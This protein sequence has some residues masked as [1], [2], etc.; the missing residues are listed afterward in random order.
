MLTIVIP[1]QE[2]YRRKT[3]TFEYLTKEYTIRLEHSLISVSKWETIYKKPY[4]TTKMNSREFV[5]YVKCMTINQDV[6]DL[7]YEAL[8]V[9]DIKKISEYIDD[10]ATATVIK[11]SSGKG[12]GSPETPTSELIYYWMITNNIPIEVCEKWRFNR[13]LTLLRICNAKGNPKKMG[14]QEIL[15][16]NALLN[17]ERCKKYN[18]KG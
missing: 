6:P 2:F 15:A 10:P 18:T 11:D 14:P 1:P 3:R 9:D 4:I 8:T 7:A 17:A 13:L 16:Q 5:D 12:H